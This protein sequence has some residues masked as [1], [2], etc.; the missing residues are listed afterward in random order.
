M[1]KQNKNKNVNLT[2]DKSNSNNWVPT[3]GT[4]IEGVSWIQNLQ[5]NFYEYNTMT[6]VMKQ[7]WIGMY[8]YMLTKQ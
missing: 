7:N 2:V 1:V 6:A 5:S 4:K 3:L 8:K